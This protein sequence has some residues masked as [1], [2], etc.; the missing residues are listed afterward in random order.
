MQLRTLDGYVPFVDR[1]PYFQHIYHLPKLTKLYA[2]M[3]KAAIT[4]QS[5]NPEFY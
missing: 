1:S 5:A 3:Y 4:F 2:G